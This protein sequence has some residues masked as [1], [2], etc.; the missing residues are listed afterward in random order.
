MIGRS[1]RECLASGRWSES[2][3]DCIGITVKKL[4]LL[5]LIVSL[6]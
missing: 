3:P 5:I 2:V 4:Y 6:L 1:T